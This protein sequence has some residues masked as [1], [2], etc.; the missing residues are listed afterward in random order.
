MV[1]INYAQER[2][3]CIADEGLMTGTIKDQG[4]DDPETDPN[5]DALARV[6]FSKLVYRL[7]CP[8]NSQRSVRVGLAGE[9]GSG[10]T[11][12][13]KWIDRFANEDKN[14]VIWYNPWSVT[15][16]DDLWATFFLEIRKSL[17]LD[18]EDRGILVDLK[19][20]FQSQKEKITAL[21]EFLSSLKGMSSIAHEFLRIT[22]EE[23]DKIRKKVNDRRIIVIIDDIDRT[24]P[25]LLPKLL[26]SL[27][28]L[29]SLPGF[30]FLLPFDAE[31]V[32]NCL[33]AYHSSWK[34]GD[35]F[36]EKIFD[37]KIDMPA[38]KENDRKFL[39]RKQL[40]QSSPSFH[41]DLAGESIDF[42]PTNPRRIKAL[43]RS[44]AVI[45]L[46]LSRH[47]PNEIDWRSLLFAAIIR[48]YSVSLFDACREKFSTASEFALAADMLNEGKESIKSTIEDVISES[49]TGR[50][51]EKC[52]EVLEK[53]WRDKS[54]FWDMK[55]RYTLRFMDEVENLTWKEFDITLSCWR[56]CEN[57]KVVFRKIEEEFAADGRRV[58]DIYSELVKALP[59]RYGEL[60]EKAAHTR[61]ASDHEVVIA[62]AEIVLD[63]M[64]AV[65][66]EIESEEYT[67][68]IFK[69]LI[70]V[71]R[72]W[73]HFNRNPGDKK[74]RQIEVDVATEIISTAEA[75]WGDYAEILYSSERKEV[76][77]E[78]QA[79][80][81]MEPIFDKIEHHI[82]EK[83]TDTF[84]SENGVNSLFASPTRE[85]VLQRLLDVEGRCWHIEPESRLISV[86]R[87]SAN[88][89]T[90]QVNAYE[91]LETIFKAHSIS[92]E[93]MKKFCSRPDA[94]LILWNA[95]IATPAQ[96]RLHSHY[97]QLHS[98]I[99][100]ALDSASDLLWP[101]WLPAQDARTKEQVA[102]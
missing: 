63:F 46:E 34:N 48:S 95:A 22:P 67:L 13:A 64:K 87:E 21:A 68:R 70:H 91:F 15:K 24:D 44:F 69:A 73:A 33:V 42:L 38:T 66:V 41:L 84:M 17:E 98:H 30:S 93:S 75:N 59:N 83:A 16:I 86:L 1:A 14:V 77:S 82:I 7:L 97:R 90:V 76:F 31:I 99:I 54:I 39:F 74:L 52:R 78:M 6:R 60:L 29:L 79:S 4:F 101:S 81:N 9:W 61:L 25:E 94:L 32:S 55:V 57:V 40:D 2:K 35:D 43:A 53:W 26:L 3:M 50:H 51:E 10:K 72:T 100:A 96:Y 85:I 56:D 36:L 45:D 62:E 58:S 27:R 37:Y 88:R 28:E 49:K 8:S 12:I 102:P 89:P 11:S 92:S 19:A 47:K 23:I 80:K 18:I 20:A 5:A 71:H 65:T